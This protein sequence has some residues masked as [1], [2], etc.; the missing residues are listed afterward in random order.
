MTFDDPGD[1][2][3]WHAHVSYDPESRNRAL[4]LREEIGSRFDVLLGRMRDEPVGPHPR[5]MF[6]AEF[7]AGE[8]ASLVPWLSLNHQGLSILIHPETGNFVADHRDN[9]LWINERLE[10]DVS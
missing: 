8:F 4:L 2:T 5:P 7:P 10:L 3:L 6:M 1:I 9:A